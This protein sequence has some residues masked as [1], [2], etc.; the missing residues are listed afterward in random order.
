MPSINDILKDLNGLK[1]QS[2][3]KVAS[4][5]S[6]Q[7]AVSK[8]RAALDQALESVQPSGNN[9]TKT[10]SA[11]DPSATASL[12]KVANELAD[13]EQSMTLKEAQLYGAAVFD[14]FVARANQYAAG[15][16]AEKVAHAQHNGS[17]ETAVKLA[18]DLGYAEAENAIQ[19]LLGQEKQARYH[20]EKTAAEDDARGV[21]AAME[22]IAELTD[23]CFERGFADAEQLVSHLS[24]Q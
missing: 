6:S 4:D 10:A 14:G 18:A 11:A 22:K 17:D 21:M 13:A 3:T 7:D 12:E 9:G 15:A 24:N 16:P 8:T 23:D 2:T 20:N 19:Q 1:D 5:T